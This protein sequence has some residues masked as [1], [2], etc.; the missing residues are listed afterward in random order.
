MF[1]I[2]AHKVSHFVSTGLSG[3]PINHN[4]S[5]SYYFIILTMR[6]MTCPRDLC[7]PRDLVTCPRDLRY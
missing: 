1:K 3:Y 6:S 5:L 2:S 4:F 7:C